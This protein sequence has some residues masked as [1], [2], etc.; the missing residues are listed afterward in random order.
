MVV[1]R[2]TIETGTFTT[3]VSQ[4]HRERQLDNSSKSP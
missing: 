2:T 4:F 1:M 3:F